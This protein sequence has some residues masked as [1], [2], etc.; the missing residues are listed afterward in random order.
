[1]A[2]TMVTS[3]FNH[4]PRID[5]GSPTILNS[6]IG[7]DD[8][9]TA[10][11]LS[12]IA[13]AW[14]E[15]RRG[16][17]NAI[18]ASLCRPA[19]P[20]PNF[21]K[22]QLKLS[23]GALGSPHAPCAEDDTGH[24]V[25]AYDTYEPLVRRRMPTMAL[26]SPPPESPAHS[27]EEHALFADK[28]MNPKLD[29]QSQEGFIEAKGKKAAKKKQG[30]WNG[31]GGDDGDGNGAEK[32]DNNGARNGG[33]QGGGNAG[34]GDADGS[35]DSNEGNGEGGGGD[36]DP[37]EDRNFTAVKKKG[38]KD[39]GKA[40]AAP[41]PAP[42]A[43]DDFDDIQ[44][45]DPGPALESKE[46]KPPTTIS[47]TWGSSF[48]TGVGWGF[49]ALNSISTANENPWSAG[50]SKKRPKNLDWILIR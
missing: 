3:F 47:S 44:L 42:S 1:M 10:T 24:E 4:L 50:A 34:A 48:G 20:R 32:E 25:D 45:D 27:Q 21:S 49:G 41:D 18:L 46:T 30:A 31:S 37:E 38:K 15:S 6:A 40:A 23:G 26:P 22:H 5:F 17:Q 35:K 8:Q 43:K 33:E 19:Q 13:R 29:F 9:D 12:Q 39:K 11:R 28:Q 2:A 36:E 14:V 16:I 7:W